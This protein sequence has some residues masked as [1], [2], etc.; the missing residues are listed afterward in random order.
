MRP[1]K[2]NTE[3][4]RERSH[5][6]LRR[7]AAHVR[8]I[9]ST[10]CRH[11]PEMRLRARRSVLVCKLGKFSGVGPVANRK[12]MRLHQLCRRLHGL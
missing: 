8:W 5:R 3:R 4:C 9:E 12:S 11:A 1:H 10:F 6:R 2:K 7:D